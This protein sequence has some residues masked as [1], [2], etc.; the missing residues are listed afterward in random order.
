MGFGSNFLCKKC[1]ETYSYQ[2]GIGFLY[3]EVKERLLEEIKDGKYGDEYKK[4]LDENPKADIDGHRIIFKCPQCSYWEDNYDL[5]LTVNGK[6]IK[7][8]NYTCPKCNIAMEVFNRNNYKTLP[9]P[10]CG[11]KNDRSMDYMWD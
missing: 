6:T 8:Y 11:E 2:I 3:Y 10:I 4:A 1:G 7:R 9:C 5:T